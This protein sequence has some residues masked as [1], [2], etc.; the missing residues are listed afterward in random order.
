MTLRPP[1][2][3]ARSEREFRIVPIN[4]VRHRRDAYRGLILKNQLEID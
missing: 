2:V 4:R 3:Y 1:P